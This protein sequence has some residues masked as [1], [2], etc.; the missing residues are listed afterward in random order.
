MFFESLAQT[1]VDAH[2]HSV[3]TKVMMFEQQLANQANAHSADFQARVRTEANQ[4][5]HAVVDQFRSEVDAKSSAAQTLGAELQQS[6]CEEAVIVSRAKEA[7]ASYEAALT[8]ARTEATSTSETNAANGVRVM[9][10]ERA[11]AGA[12]EECARAQAVVARDE[13][14]SKEQDNFVI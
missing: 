13:M 7:L 10:L 3:H 2:E 8:S 5:L 6:R 9:A 12:E 14:R 1:A 11:L 4:E